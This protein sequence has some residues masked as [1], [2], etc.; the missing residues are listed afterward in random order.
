[1]REVY[2][3]KQR[4]DVRPNDG[5]G[6]IFTSPIFRDITKILS[7]RTTSYKIPK[8]A[9]NIGIFQHSDKPDVASNFPK[10]EYDFEEYRGGLLFIAGKCRLL[11]SA[12]DDFEL[13]VNW[14]NAINL[15]GLKDLKLRECYVDTIYPYEPY[16]YWDNN[17]SFMQS[18]HKD[19]LGFLVVDYGKGL[20]DKQGMRPAINV[21]GVLD[22]IE[23]SAKVKFKYPM[24]FEEV[25]KKKWIPILDNNT[26]E[27]AWRVN[28]YRINAHWSGRTFPVG[29]MKGLGWFMEADYGDP[30][31]I[32]TSNGLV[33]WEGNDFGIDSKIKMTAKVQLK[34]PTYPLQMKLSWCKVAYQPAYKVGEI[35]IPEILL[36]KE[37]INSQIADLAS[38]KDGFGHYNFEMDSSGM[39]ENYKEGGQFLFVVSAVNEDVDIKTLEVETSK[40][41]IT[42]KNKETKFGEVLSIIP[43]LPDLKV[44]DFLK[45]L[46]HMY[47]LFTYYDHRKAGLGTTVE[48]ISIDDIY[49][50]FKAEAYDWTDKLVSNGRGMEIS[51][52][53]GNYARTNYFKYATD[54]TV[55]V[56]ADGMFAIDNDIIDDEATLVE[57]PYTPSENDA[58]ENGTFASI[59]LFNNDGSRNNITTRFL[60]EGGYEVDSNGDERFY[61]S[62]VFDDEM[63]FS[64]WRGLLN[65]YYKGYQNVVENP[66]VV[67]FEVM[68]NEAELYLY[69][70]VIPVFIE[71]TYY[72]ILKLTASSVSDDKWKCQ[73]EAIK[74]PPLK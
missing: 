20:A 51:Y 67:K 63:S 7:N 46:M 38:M 59:K 18:S 2:I 8:T 66:I 21:R 48:F 58:N 53:Y 25:F 26:D 69:R 11:T 17:S 12:E 71:G 31:K 32:I 74:M 19:D 15:M 27:F 55:P 35:S 73:C 50:K 24:Q 5:V 47:G 3:N 30:R 44:V 68:L 4:V 65:K 33:S 34:Y 57:L 37:T 14:G 54:D 41:E 9:R 70:E 43:N 49:T 29:K 23:N 1:M 16:V 61:I 39:A 40:L 45:T 56:N 64:G 6:Y 22:I 10:R 62:A 28:D 13:A 60:N 42:I 72:M 36:R 52:N